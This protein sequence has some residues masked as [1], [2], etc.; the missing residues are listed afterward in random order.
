MQANR[1][2][3]I[4]GILLKSF[5]FVM[6][7]FQN[8][9]NEVQ[10]YKVLFNEKEDVLEIVFVPKQSKN[11]EKMLGGRTIYGREIHYHV[12]IKNWEIIKKHFAK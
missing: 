10:N 12:S 7:D 5:L 9:K 8:E 6:Q 4:D 3:E 11:G 2:I 1:Q